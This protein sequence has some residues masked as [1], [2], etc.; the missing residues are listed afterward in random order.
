MCK[1]SKLA[2]LKSIGY[3]SIEFV[4]LEHSSLGR[5]F[6]FYT[7]ESEV[8][9]V[10]IYQQHIVRRSKNTKQHSKYSHKNFSARFSVS[11]NKL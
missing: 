7:R 10:Q 5:R 3:A 4:C 8:I 9:P 2:E 11:Q 1:S 6:V